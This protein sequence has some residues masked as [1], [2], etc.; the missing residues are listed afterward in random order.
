MA[1]PQVHVKTGKK[2]NGCGKIFDKGSFTLNISTR[3]G[4]FIVKYLMCGSCY[5]AYKKGK[6]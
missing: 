5:E 3:E 2:C 4:L 1:S 6:K